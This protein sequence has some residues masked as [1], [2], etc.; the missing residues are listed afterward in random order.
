VYTSSSGR[1]RYLSSTGNDLVLD[2]CVLDLTNFSMTTQTIPHI[3]SST[4]NYL[5]GEAQVGSEYEV[6]VDGTITTP[7]GTTATFTFDFFIDGAAF[8][9]STKITVGGVIIQT[10]FTYSFTLRCR[11][12][13]EATGAGGTAT[14]TMDGGMTRKN[15]NVGNAQQFTTLNNTEVNASIDTTANHSLA[16]YCNWSSTVGTGHSAVTYRT[17]KTRRN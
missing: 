13:I 4:L 16:V 5:G 14:I 8:T 15:V 2:R 3:L 12:T 7:A 10:G 6:E 9:A 1:L 17:K 11:A